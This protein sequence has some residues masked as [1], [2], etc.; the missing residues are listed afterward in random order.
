MKSTSQGCETYFVV[1]FSCEDLERV[2]NIFISKR[3]SFSCLVS[4]FEKKRSSWIS[5]PWMSVFKAHPPNTRTRMI[6]I[7]SARKIHFYSSALFSFPNCAKSCPKNG[8]L[9][10][11]FC[12]F[13]SVYSLWSSFSPTVRFVLLLFWMVRAKNRDKKTYQVLHFPT[14]YKRSFPS[15]EWNFT[16]YSWGICWVFYFFKNW[17]VG[18]HVIIETW[19]TCSKFWYVSPADTLQTS[20]TQKRVN[21]KSPS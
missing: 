12:S 13:S 5:F 19:H 4:C 3:L 14:N 15:P 9:S 20:Q 10:D 17:T 1:D 11:F 21:N 18:S 2:A 8:W 16:S 7:N 6:I